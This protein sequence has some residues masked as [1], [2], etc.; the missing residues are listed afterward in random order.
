MSG[1]PNPSRITDAMWRLWLALKAL[2]PSTQ[3]GGIYARKPGYHNTRDGNS[4]GDYSVR[5]PQDRRGPSDKAAAIDWT[6]PSAQ[7]GDYRLIARYMS[8]VIASGKDRHDERLN[9]WR[10]VYGQA[11]ND[12]HVEGWDCRYLR[13][14]TSDPSHRWHIHFSESR[15]HANSWPN[16]D[17]LL[18]VL[19][20]EPLAAWRARTNGTPKPPPAPA[21]GTMCKGKLRPVLRRGSKGEHVRF[22]QAMIGAKVDGDYGPATEARVR[23]YQK[24]RGLSVDGVA[25]PATWNSINRM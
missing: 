16:K 12:G 5:D 4:S 24:M 21:S 14:V 11:D 3:L 13:E 18:S 9:G 15:E 19:K 6:F 25:G 2:E 8:R 1:N 17:A 7:R 20:G 23:W 22:L 10:E